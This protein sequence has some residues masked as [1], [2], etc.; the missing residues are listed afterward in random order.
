MATRTITHELRSRAAALLI[1]TATAGL[2]R[3]Y[4]YVADPTPLTGSVSDAVDCAD[5]QVAA[6]R[7]AVAAKR[8]YS[9]SMCQVIRNVPYVS[10]TVYDRY[11]DTVDISALNY[12]AVVNAGAYSHVW[13]CLDNDNGAQTSIA[14]NVSDIDSYTETYDVDGYSWK[15][16]YSVPSST[17][18]TFATTSWFPLGS[19]ASVVAATVDGDVRSF[20]VANGGAGYSNYLTGAFSGADCQVGNATT[21]SVGSGANAVAGFY[22]GCLLYLASGTGSG[23]SRTVANSFA[24]TTGRYV[25]AASPFTVSPQNLTGWELY[26]EV[27]ITG[28]GAQTVNAVARALV[29]SVSGNSVYSVQ[30]MNRGAGYGYA[31]AVVATDPSVGVT[32]ASVRVV[33]SPPGG[34]GSD[35]GGEL[36]ATAVCLSVTLANSEA[37]TIPYTGS[38]RRMGVW[39]D[40]L[41]SGVSVTLTG[42]TGSFVTGELIYGVD[43]RALPGTANAVAG[44]PDYAYGSV[45]SLRVL[46]WVYLVSSD[47]TNRQLAQVASVNSTAF[48][49]AANSSWSDTGSSVYLASVSLA[50]TASAVP[51]GSHVTLDE[52]TSVA[53]ANAVLV[54]ATSGA[55]GTVSSV[56]RSGQAK[57]FDTFTCLGKILTGANTGTFTPGETVTATAG[58]SALLYGYTFASGVGTALISNSVGAMT[59]TITGATSGASASVTTVYPGEV[60]PRTGRVLFVENIQPV[61]RSANTSE[62]LQVV[63]T[64]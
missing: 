26:P 10:G 38:F 19:N 57:G 16:M 6:T 44:S 11:D 48:V 29:N 31:S 53:V 37:N 42:V 9:N 64:F 50:G 46:D 33:M 45:A 58:G 63:I 22:K 28:D 3:I 52:A 62:T 25:V 55:R 5:L 18:A 8:A 24:N 36:G 47:S 61:T 30:V 2:T 17:V 4:A 15:Y 27:V 21:Y 49:A 12:Y 54:G 20:V 32:N 41:F 43:A 23:Q 1:T 40:P 13:V 59:G 56:S 39:A 34:H 14:P 51:D 60:D 35:P 7:D